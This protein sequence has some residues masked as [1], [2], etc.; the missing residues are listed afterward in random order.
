MEKGASRYSERNWEKG[1]PF[2][3]CVASLFRHLNAYMRGERGA[4]FEDHLAA[5]RANAAFLMHYEEMIENGKL[6]PSLD[7]LPRYDPEQVPI[8]PEPDEKLDASN[9]TTFCHSSL[10]ARDPVYEKDAMEM[11]EKAL[12][13]K[14][15]KQ[16]LVDWILSHPQCWTQYCRG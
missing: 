14:A 11:L 10:G 16:R 9:T 12:E 3:R 6:P 13:D 15:G 7:D 1:I 8:T 2:S 5:I 4:N